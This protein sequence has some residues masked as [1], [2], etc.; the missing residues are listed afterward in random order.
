M[1]K[2]GV[3]LWV[4]ATDQTCFWGSDPIDDLDSTPLK[5]L[6]SHTSTVGQLA[7]MAARF[8]MGKGFTGK[9]KNKERE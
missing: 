6:A 7:V 9:L 4:D 1:R 2:P 3:L 8:H 5:L